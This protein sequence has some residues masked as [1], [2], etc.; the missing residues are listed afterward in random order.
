LRDWIIL[1]GEG[2]FKL[3]GQKGRRLLQIRAT[4]VGIR[5]LSAF[6]AALCLHYLSSFFCFLA[7]LSLFSGLLQLATQMS[8]KGSLSW[9]WPLSLCVCLL[10]SAGGFLAYTVWDKT[11]LRAFQIE[12]LVD[13]ALGSSPPVKP[14]RKSPENEGASGVDSDAIVRIVEEVLER[15]FRGEVGQS[16]NP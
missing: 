8:E 14:E 12:Q 3:I 10:L 5:I 1:L 4:A 15:K 11:W 16:K 2:I 13:S 7:A 9:T 6:R